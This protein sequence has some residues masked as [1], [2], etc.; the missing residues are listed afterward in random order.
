MKF[1]KTASRVLIGSLVAGSLAACGNGETVAD[2]PTT[3]TIGVWGGNSAEEETLAQMLEEFTEK[4]GIIVEP[5][6]YTEFET[7]LQT[8]LIGGTAPD[9][10]YVEAFL[11]PMWER[12]G[13]LANLDEFIASS[14]GFDLDD[15]Y[16]PALNA[17]TTERGVYGIPKD[18][19]TLGLY[20]NVGLLEAAGFTGDD[21]P[22]VMSE[23]PAFLAELAP[24]LPAG[25]VP[26]ITSSELARHMFVLQANGTNVIGEDGLASFTAPG[27][28]EYLQMLVD[29][30]QEGLVQ[31]PADLGQGWAGDSFGV[32]A[33]AIMIEGNWA[34][35]HIQNN[36]PNVEIGTRAIPTMA[37]NNASMMF[38]VSWSMNANTQN[39]EAAWKFIEFMTGQEG[40]TQWAGGASLIP[41]RHSSSDALNLS[42]T[43]LAPFAEAA[44]Y[45]TPWR[46]GYTLSI[47]MRE[48]NNMIPAALSGQMTLQE[49]MEEAERVANNDIAT[50]LQ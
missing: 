38:T 9:V 46:A 22:T 47:A 11:F 16:A 31:R 45:A 49:A 28:L 4:T 23:L 50:H 17:F 34:I 3:I 15:F 19:S 35:G 21:I 27:Q 42:E 7:Q 48:F 12:E 8:D 33:A 18:L 2:G 43:L 29:A 6:V 13:V 20:Y 37:G 32:E 14:E 25:V 41:S 5:R 10:F 30:Y 40:M 26:A 24:N 1:W 36:F 39:P 44:D